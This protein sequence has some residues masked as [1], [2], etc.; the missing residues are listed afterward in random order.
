MKSFTDYYLEQIGGKS[1]KSKKWKKNMTSIYRKSKL[2]NNRF[3]LLDAIEKM[4]KLS[5]KNK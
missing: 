3:K 1:K 2:K 5:K 4:N